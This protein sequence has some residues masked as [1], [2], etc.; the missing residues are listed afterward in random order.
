[1]IVLTAV[2]Y[3]VSSKLIRYIPTILASGLVLFLGI[4]LT[5]EA[6]WESAKYFVWSEWLVVMATLFACTFVGFAQGVGVGICAAFVV[7][8]GWGCFDLVSNPNR[9]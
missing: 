8:T 1:M 9:E 3:V 5:L 4:E 7:Y 6:V 2:L